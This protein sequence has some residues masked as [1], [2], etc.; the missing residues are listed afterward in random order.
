MRRL[1]IYGLNH[2]PGH[3]GDKEPDGYWDSTFTVNDIT[4]GN[5]L[6]YTVFQ[7]LHMHESYSNSQKFLCESSK[8]LLSFE[9]FLYLLIYM[10]SLL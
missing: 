4:L 1:I 2:G 5:S 7:C 10:N 3:Q 6:N 8:N 9:L